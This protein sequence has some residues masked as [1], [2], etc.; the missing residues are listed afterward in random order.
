MVAVGLRPIPR[1]LELSGV[2]R[3]IQTAES[4]RRALAQ[5]QGGERDAR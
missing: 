3:V 1:T 4:E 2:L 5:L